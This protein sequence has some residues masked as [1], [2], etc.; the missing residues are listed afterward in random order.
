ME[1]VGV[2]RRSREADEYYGPAKSNSFITWMWRMGGP[3][4]PLAVRIAQ[5]TKSVVVGMFIPLLEGWRL[6]PLATW[7]MEH[8]FNQ[9][10]HLKIG[11]APWE[12]F[13]PAEMF[14]GM[15]LSDGVMG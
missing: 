7:R 12:P 13:E 1:I 11:D 5:M 4:V 3:R 9:L 2:S 6:D 14:S 15:F 8:Q 10:S